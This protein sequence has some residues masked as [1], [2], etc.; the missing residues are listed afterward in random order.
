MELDRQRAAVGW[1]AYQ[2]G[3]CFEPKSALGLIERAACFDPALA[4][5]AAERAGS[6]G[7]AFPSWRSVVNAACR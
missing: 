6:K 7:S 3:R 1:E 5:L 4:P 2:P